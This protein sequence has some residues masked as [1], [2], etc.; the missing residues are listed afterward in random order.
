[1]NKENLL[2][3]TML[4]EPLISAALTGVRLWR[5]KQKRRLP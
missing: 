4:R 2:M 3:S 5:K 1:M